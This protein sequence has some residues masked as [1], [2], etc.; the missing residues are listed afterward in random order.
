[1]KSRLEKCIM[2][3]EWLLKQSDDGIVR[4]IQQ[5][6]HIHQGIGG[7]TYFILINGIPVFL[8][9]IPLTA[10]E[11]KN[12]RSTKNIFNLPMYYQY[13][14]G[15]TGFGVW[16]ELAAHEQC[17]AW[18]ESGLLPNFPLLFHWR[19][20]DY[21]ASNSKMDDEA[22]SKEVGYW[23]HSEAVRERLLAIRDS[24]TCIILICEYFPKNLQDWFSNEILAD[25]TRAL[26][27]IDHV[28]KSLLA[29]NNFMISQNM[30]HFDAHFRNYEELV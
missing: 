25:D 19:E 2:L 27:A 5:S 26:K 23:N 1:M 17:Q 9:A 12:Y 21:K 20:I 6:N 22:I 30:I 24:K 29:I 7:D 10:L 16:R 8:K 13:G 3:Q 28:E 11:K 15:S 18:V 4:L 14:V